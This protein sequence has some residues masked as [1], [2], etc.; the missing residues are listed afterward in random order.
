MSV[1]V[2]VCANVQRRGVGVLVACGLCTV[3]D[4]TVAL[5]QHAGI[6]PSRLRLVP[7]A[8]RLCEEDNGLLEIWVCP[9][10]DMLDPN[11]EGS[12]EGP[13]GTHAAYNRLQRCFL[14]L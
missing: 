14:C 13:V 5:L 4:L 2:C 6:K 11:G 7:P 9:L 1:F 8:G 10:A 3:T 12:E